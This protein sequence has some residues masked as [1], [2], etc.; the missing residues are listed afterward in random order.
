MKATDIA[1]SLVAA[2]GLAS[3]LNLNGKGCIGGVFTIE[4]QNWKG[5]L[6]FNP[7]SDHPNAHDVYG[8]SDV[9]P[10]GSLLDWN[11]LFSF[12]YCDDGT[13]VK[14]KSHKHNAYLSM[15]HPWHNVFEPVPTN[16]P[17]HDNSQCFQLVPVVPSPVDNRYLI[18]SM[19]TGAGKD[20]VLQGLRVGST[21]YNYP[22]NSMIGVPED[23]PRPEGENGVGAGIDPFESIKWNIRYIGEEADYPV[24]TKPEFDL[25]G[26]GGISGTFT[27][28]NVQWQG[29]LAYD[30]DST[31]WA[32][33]EHG[34]ISVLSPSDSINVNTTF[35]AEY[36]DQL[37]EF[38]SCDQETIMNYSGENLLVKIKTHETKKFYTAWHP[39]HNVFLVPSN[40]PSSQCF[41]LVPVV[42]S[43]VKNRFLIK[44]MDTG[45][46]KDL[47][48]QGLRVGSTFYNHPGNSIIGVPEHS[49]RVEGENGVG[50]G[51]EP[52]ESIKW[53]INF[54]R[55]EFDL[56]CDH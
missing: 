27:I 44:F 4:N 17:D 28:E 40:T 10:A 41:E 24:D 37:F 14:I 9:L 11:Q 1:A 3:G 6:A 53:D 8:Q 5:N 43:P 33:G 16:Q 34:E 2:A 20:L 56:D 19:H 50:V 22:G 39:W 54:Y 30:D 38:E 21:F 45:A 55:F 12:E 13:S 51:I 42:P 7:N 23:S 29:N 15:W 31:S 32:A 48:L 52:F 49:P 35:K 47:V 36:E 25:N 46:G 18:K 26:F